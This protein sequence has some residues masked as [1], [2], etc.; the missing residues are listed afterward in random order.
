MQ[1]RIFIRKRPPRRSV[2]G[3]DGE[4]HGIRGY[5]PGGTVHCAGPRP[6]P[7]ARH[8][9]TLSPPSRRSKNVFAVPVAITYNERASEDR[10]SERKRP[11]K[12]L[13]MQARGEDR[14]LRGHPWIFSN[15]VK[16]DLKAF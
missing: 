2:A 11:L 6:A 5:R 12:P 4:G 9:V 16:E 15:Q 1:A 8:L 3:D 14:V 7:A 13:H 10:E